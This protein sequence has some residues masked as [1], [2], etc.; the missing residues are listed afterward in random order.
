MLCALTVRKLKPGTFE[1]F[2]ARFWPEEQPPP[3]NWNTFHMLRNTDDETEV[4]TI[5]FFDGTAAELRTSQRE[6]GYDERVEEIT[7]LV[8]SVLA[9]GIYEFEVAVESTASR[10]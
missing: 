3:G 4:V 9:T 7:P 10:T 5:G 6:Q 2:R 8:A 1:E